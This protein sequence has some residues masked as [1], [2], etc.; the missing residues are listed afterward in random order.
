MQWNIYQRFLY[1]LLPNR[2]IKIL[3]DQKYTGQ[4][5]RASQV[6]AGIFPFLLIPYPKLS[7]DLLQVAILAGKDIPKFKWVAFLV[8]LSFV[9]TSLHIQVQIF[10]VK[11]QNCWVNVKLG[12][13]A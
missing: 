1:S 10:F 8:N 12:I 11:M 5:D 3:I 13:Y 2:L 9:Q 6:R 4:I 7:T